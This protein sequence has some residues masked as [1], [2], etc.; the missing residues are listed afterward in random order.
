MTGRACFLGLDVGTGGCKAV[1]IDRAGRVLADATS[2]Y[3]LSTPRPQWSEQDPHD[4]WGGAVA[5]IAAVLAAAG[6]SGPD[7]AAVGLTGQMHGLVLLDE[8]GAVLRPAILW[9]DQR[10]AAECEAIHERVGRDRLIAISGKPALPGFTAPKILWVRR[11]EPHVF[12]AAS[13]MLLP[14]DYV[15]L[16]L[17][18]ARRTDVA[19]ASGTSLLDIAQRRWSDEML[20]ALEVPR[21]WL[22]EVDESP[23]AAAAVSAEAAALTGLVAGTPVAAGAGDQAA[24]AVGCGI[25]EP[26]TVSVSIG[27]SGV[28]FAA[29]AAPGTDPEAR[30]HGYAHAVP[31]R[32]HVMGVMLSAGGSLRWYRDTIAPG[33]PYDRLLDGAAGVP[34]GC[35]GLYFLPYLTGERSPH[36]DPHARGAFVGLTL[37]HG[38]DHLTRAVLEGVTFG[39]RDSLELVRRHL[40][41]VT[42]VR[43]SGG[44]TRSEL[45]RRLMADVF[46]A[47]VATVNAVHGAAFGAALLA[48]VAGGAWADVPAAVGHVVREMAV[49]EPGPQLAA[50]D[51]HYARYRALYPALVGEFRGI[52][53]VI[54]PSLPK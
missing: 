11:H 49:I 52:S 48:G 44:G 19:D 2:A 31:G 46:G 13:T 14:K 16:R 21:R 9:N 37:R 12:A 18:G 10:C 45:W 53:A 29:A 41:P 47:E 35:E 6:R 24:E 34:P 28:V 5:A 23:V 42:R 36:P 15:R 25:I 7:V 17:T 38:R 54:E 8:A 33:E 3:G 43:V 4:W 27:T 1:L 22:P 30:L 50:Y 40:G 39:L 32:W 51:A 26:G 20:D